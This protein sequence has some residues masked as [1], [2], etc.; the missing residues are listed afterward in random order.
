M[1]APAP[2]TALEPSSPARIISR[3]KGGPHA[4]LATPL[5]RIPPAQNGWR[6]L[7]CPSKASG[8]RGSCA[9]PANE[10]VRC[11][12]GAQRGAKIHLRRGHQP[13]R[14]PSP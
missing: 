8:Q 2:A 12:A 14:V 7:K 6:L 10:G 13:V 4:Y 1:A 9:Y 3:G 11:G 5:A